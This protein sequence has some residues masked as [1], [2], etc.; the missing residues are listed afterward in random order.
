VPSVGPK[1]AES[2]YAYFHDEQNLDVLRR[3]EEAGVRMVGGAPAAR[4]GPLL[5]LTIVATGSLTRWSRNEVETLIKRLGGAVGSSV[6]K[7]TDYVVAGENP[8]SKPAGPKSTGSRYS[9]KTLLPTCSLV[10]AAV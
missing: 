10:G 4:E 7:K 6:T 9:T 5:G 2:V 1:I 3:M 8:G